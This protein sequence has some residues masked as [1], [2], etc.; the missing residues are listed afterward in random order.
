M[1]RR[2]KPGKAD[3]SWD[4]RSIWWPQS[5]DAGIPGGDSNLWMCA[6]DLG[7][8]IWTHFYR[9]EQRHSR[10]EVEPLRIENCQ[11]DLQE[12]L[13]NCLPFNQ[14]RDDLLGSVSSFVQLVAQDFVLHGGI[15][16]EA[17]GEWDRS[18]APPKLE[19]AALVMIPRGSVVRLGGIVLQVVPSGIK[20]ESSKGHII[21]LD[22]TRLVHFKPP[23]RLQPALARIR[24]GLPVIGESENKWMMGMA[25]RKVS[26]IFKDVNLAYCIQRAQITAPIGWNARGR[27][28][29]YIADFHWTVRELRWQ[30]FC[31]E[32]R[33]SI[34]KTIGDVFALIGSWRGEQW[35][36]GGKL[37]SLSRSQLEHEPAG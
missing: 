15:L 36:A 18:I 4:G 34:L 9:L 2:T 24:A 13:I 11:D 17:R 32:I 37:D 30:R 31:I 27:F 35:S 22:Q 23:R 12:V 28:R 21:R 20:N 10:H 6:E 3:L 26:E 1:R 19:N 16:F 7:T 33:D 29:D 8:A 14:Y 25:Q 5:H